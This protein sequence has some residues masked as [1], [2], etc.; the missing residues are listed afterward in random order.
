MRIVTKFRRRR[1][2][3]KNNR[4]PNTSRARSRR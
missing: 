4:L 2:L 1:R 3:F